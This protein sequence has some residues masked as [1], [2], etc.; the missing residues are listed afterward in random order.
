MKIPKDLKSKL[1]PIT[2]IYLPREKYDTALD[3]LLEL[4]GKFPNFHI[5]DYYIGISYMNLA[6]VS[7]ALKYLMPL[8]RSNQLTILQL[9]QG[10]MIQGLI[11]TDAQEYDR[12]EQVFK[13]AIEAHPQSSMA[14]SALGYIYY[15]IKRYDEA[16]RNFKVAIE[17][18]PNNPS[19]HN[20]LCF[21]YAEIGININ[22]A[23]VEGRKAVALDPNSA[24][25][26]DSLGWAYFMA[27][28]YNSAVKQL[29]KAFELYPN[30]PDI[31]E[32][33]EKAKKKSMPRPRRKS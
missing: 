24:A 32:H 23:L 1:T 26:H 31:I 6:D 29:Q 17:L 13:A 18:D 11:F 12:A 16:I 22:E 14:H 2:D 20:N 33:L 7:Q 5:V 25:Y 8:T 4:K 28:D 3:L 30:H 27:Q 19:A 10:N 15:L 9:V 21:T